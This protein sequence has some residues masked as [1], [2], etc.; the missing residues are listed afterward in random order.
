[1]RRR[2]DVGDVGGGSR[3]ARR[4]RRRCRNPSRR[5]GSYS[6]WRRDRPRGRLRMRQR[7]NLRER[8]AEQSQLLVMI[9]QC[10]CDKHCDDRARAQIAPPTPPLERIRID[11]AIRSRATEADSVAVR[12]LLL[13]ANPPSIEI[14]AF[15]RFQIDNIVTAACVSDDCVTTR[16]ARIRNAQSRPVCAAD[17]ALHRARAA[18]A[19]CPAAS[20]STASRRAA[21]G[22]FSTC[23]YSRRHTFRR[24]T[25]CPST[26]ARPEFPCSKAPVRRSRRRSAACSF[27]RSC[28]QLFCPVS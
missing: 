6:R 7:R 23:G 2:C 20:R 5:V 8:G 15:G 19:A 28:W 13:A 4:P 1:M 3:D 21:C 12:E 18:A 14:G 17:V 9:H 25:R 26:A 16:D 27:A 11:K 10:E 22:L 24:R